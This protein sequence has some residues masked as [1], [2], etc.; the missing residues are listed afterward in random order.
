[1]SLNYTK[2]KEFSLC[3]FYKKLS[4]I[5]FAQRTSVK[6]D[7]SLTPSIFQVQGRVILPK[8]CWSSVLW[9]Q[10]WFNLTSVNDEY[11]KCR[12]E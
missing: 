2:R 6:S 1:L 10:L 5:H 7:E 3:A 4:F 11:A 9:A 8:N 12:L